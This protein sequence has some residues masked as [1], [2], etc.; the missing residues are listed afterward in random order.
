MESRL[1][2]KL[3]FCRGPLLYVNHNGE[4][5]YKRV[6]YPATISP[7]QITI[8]TPFSI[9]PS[10]PSYGL[11]T[12]VCDNVFVS[13]NLIRLLT[14]GGA[15]YI[16]TKDPNVFDQIRNEVVPFQLEK[17]GD[18][19]A[20][21]LCR[22][23]LDLEGWYGNQLMANFIFTRYRYESFFTDYISAMREMRI[24]ITDIEGGPQEYNSYL[25]Y[26]LSKQTPWS[27]GEDEMYCERKKQISASSKRNF[28]VV[29][30]K[31]GRMQLTT[32][33]LP[34]SYV[35]GVLFR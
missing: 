4:S 33:P 24:Y 14:P 11:H 34:G 25:R 8:A 27:V 17:V 2:E 1:T 5:R 7:E 13:H 22:K 32:E 15:L 20:C 10:L 30:Y 18:L 9:D 6:T 3:R 21:L 29:V 28:C 35:A 31:D 16:E 12:I 26:W 23:G 19:Y